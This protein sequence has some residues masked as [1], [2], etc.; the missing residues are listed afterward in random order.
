MKSGNVH[1]IKTE[2][3]GELKGASHLIFSEKEVNKLYKACVPESIV[4]DNSSQS[5]IMKE[6]FLSEIDNMVANAVITE[7]SNFLDIEI[8]GQEP[9][10]KILDSS[11]VD[12]YLVEESKKLIQLF[13]LKQYFM[14]HN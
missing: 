4:F 11:E 8:F 7:F 2:L 9:S 12:D 1:L 6:G 14:E 13:I 10:L 3:M 5:A